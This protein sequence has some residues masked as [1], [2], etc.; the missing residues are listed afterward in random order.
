MLVEVWSELTRV[1]GL[2]DEQLATFAWLWYVVLW[3][4]VGPI[5]SSMSAAWEI[6]AS[7]QV[8][9]GRGKS[10]CVWLGRVRSSFTT[11]YEFRHPTSAGIKYQCI[12]FIFKSIVTTRRVAGHPKIR[13]LPYYPILPIQTYLLN[14]YR[15]L[16][17]YTCSH[18]RLN[19]IQTETC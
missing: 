13:S 17:C 8:E 14:Y 19:K 6:S 7:R 3:C 18:P 16:R 4:W 1:G 9:I 11:F 2:S 10:S 5:V 12:N 15:G